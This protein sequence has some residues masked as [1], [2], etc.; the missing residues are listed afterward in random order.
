MQPQAFASCMLPLFETGLNPSDCT[1]KIHVQLKLIP[2]R[3]ITS[4]SPSNNLSCRFPKVV[5]Q[6]AGFNSTPHST[7]WH[8]IGVWRYRISPPSTH[9][10]SP[11]LLFI[12]TTHK[13]RLLPVFMGQLATACSKRATEMSM[14]HTGW[15][16]CTRCV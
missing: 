16:W 5:N 9:S 8:S 12:N 14:S 3:A 4:V 11:C 7:T 6:A 15:A 1:L 10:L 13:L 2:C